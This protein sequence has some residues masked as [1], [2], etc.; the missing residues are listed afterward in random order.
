M[1]E[2]VPP[3]YTQQ[4]W[5][6]KNPSYPLS[7]LRMKHIEAGVSA[8]EAFT[9][10]VEEYTAAQLLANTEASPHA[11]A[12]AQQTLLEG[13]SPTV[14]EEAATSIASPITIPTLVEFHN[15]N[16]AA[17]WV[18]QQADMAENKETEF[19]CPLQPYVNRLSNGVFPYQIMFDFDGEAFG[20]HFSTGEKK[21]R[22][23]VW[24]N[25]VCSAYSEPKRGS[26]YLKV[27]F[28]SRAQ[29][30]IILECDFNIFLGA[31]IRSK[32]DTISAPSEYANRTFAVMGDSFGRG[33]GILEGETEPRASAQSYT[34]TL[35][36]L[37]GYTQTRNYSVP[38]TGFC[39][40]A[41]AAGTYGE[42]L[43][44]PLAAYKPNVLLLQGSTND[45]TYAGSGVVKKAIEELVAAARVASPATT[46]VGCTPMP[47]S[48]AT[49]TENEVNAAECAEAFT[50]LKVPYADG[51]KLEW[52]TGTGKV[53]A[54]TGEGN[55]D[56][57][58]SAITA[59]HPSLAGH[60][61]LAL[62][63]AQALAPALGVAL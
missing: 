40:P 1:T 57:Y 23:R 20:M 47:I 44:V 24:A 6:D 58:S 30:R 12:Q 60:N 37:L 51:F 5:Q 61:Y 9:K 3:G 10:A 17:P 45:H 36:R 34:Y 15:L 54:T 2:P 48:N 16:P 25:D 18:Y 14:T 63:L 62:R 28:G 32:T 43:P 22:I 41:G 56:Y 49:R 19:I 7:A 50:A 11:Q 27:S 46:I 8:E 29:R 55:S 26:Y 33:S 59:G 21:S 52:I 4:E 35:A 13:L 38:G 53:G 31:L 39:N 42:R